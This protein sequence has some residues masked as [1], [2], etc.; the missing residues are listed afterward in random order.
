MPTVLN[1]TLVKGVAQSN[2]S[3]SSQPPSSQPLSQLSQRTLPSTPHNTQSSQPSM[4]SQSQPSQSLSTNI[5]ALL[6]ALNGGD[7][8]ELEQKPVEL[9]TE[10][11][12]R[13]F[14]DE[15]GAKWAQLE[16]DFAAGRYRSAIAV[17]EEGTVES[18][19]VDEHPEEDDDRAV[20][21]Y[22]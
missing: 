8:D 21:L 20:D 5:D 1:C 16:Q 18:G 12:S 17:Q 22:D 3:T 9:S 4:F 10:E 15:L 19:E 14:I 13:A 7:L 6:F 2:G 11:R